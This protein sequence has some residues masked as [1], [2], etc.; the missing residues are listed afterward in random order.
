VANT[1]NND[2]GKPGKGRP[3]KGKPTPKQA[4]GGKAAA[5]RAPAKPVRGKG[6]QKSRQGRAKPGE[7][8]GLMKFLKDVRIEMGKV[9]WP[10]R[11]DL[12]QST[13][14][15]LVAVAIATVYCFGLDTVFAKTVDMILTVIK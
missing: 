3:G 4:Q 5:K 1:A 11:K 13:L 9:T 15:V 2:T 12:M 7:K 8:R 6:Q 10:T 14:V